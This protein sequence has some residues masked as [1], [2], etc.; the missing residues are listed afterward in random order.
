[1]NNLR[2][3]L[4]HITG[5]YRYDIALSFAEEDRTFVS[6]V[7]QHLKA[8]G[9]TIFYDDDKRIETLGMDLYAYLDK[10]YREDAQHCLMFISKHY[11]VK[12]WTGREKDWSVV[13]SFV[14]KNKAYIFPIR[15]DDTEIDGISNAIAYLSAT[16]FDTEQLADIVSK[17]VEKNRPGLYHVRRKTKRFFASKTRASA[18]VLL[19]IGSAV[20]G[21]RDH[22]T[23]VDTLAKEL[24][25]RDKKV[26]HGSVCRDSSFSYHRGSGACSHHGGVAYKKDSIMH[27]KTIEECWEEAK[28]IF[29]FSK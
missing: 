24:Y 18:S 13:R 26:V 3:T 4:S 28:K 11:A 17:S 8:R 22:F 7:A 27:S 10:I 25:E 5:I 9:M 23:P 15:L 19:I 12:K 21:L 20:F 6:E 29:W 16:I 2:S 1:M 14:H